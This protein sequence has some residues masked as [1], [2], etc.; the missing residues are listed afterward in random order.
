LCDARN[1]IAH[2]KLLTRDGETFFDLF[3][4]VMGM[5]ENVR[6]LIIVHARQSRYRDAP[7]SGVQGSH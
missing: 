5:L 4:N 1:E 7:L 6:T 2:G 3:K